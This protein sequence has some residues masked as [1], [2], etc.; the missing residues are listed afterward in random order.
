MVEEDKSKE[1]RF[2]KSEEKKLESKEER[3]ETEEKKP[4]V[5]DAEREEV[6]EKKEVEK[7]EDEQVEAEK[8]VEKKEEKSKGEPEEG[9]EGR[10]EKKRVEEKKEEKKGKKEKKFEHNSRKSLKESIRN[11]YVKKYKTV[12]AM[13]FT[14]FLILFLSIFIFSFQRGYLLNKDISLKGGVVV[15]LPLKNEADFNV[16]IS[17][18]RS[19]FPNKD[20]TVRLLGTTSKSIS[21]ESSD[22]NKTQILSVLSQI[23]DFSDVIKSNNYTFITVG[24][25]LG[26]SFFKQTIKA[27]IW[28][29]IL[30][31]VVV[32]LY[33][34]NF[35]PSL[36]VAWNA[37]ADLAETLA[38]IVMLNMKFSTASIAALLMLIG[39]SVDTNILLTSRVLKAARDKIIPLIFNSMRTGLAMS[40]TTMVTTFFAYLVT[41]SMV[42]RQIMFILTVGMV[43]DTIN[44]WLF[45]A[46]L[47]RWYLE[48]KYSS[49]RK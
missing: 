29:F 47:L 49:R 8:G 36:F 32:L 3:K 38:V 7:K 1:K 26:E 35:T 6:K 10:K 15:T 44:T 18:F 16:V 27:I 9:E 40:L 37:F 48:N 19:A 13:S 33:F 22:L 39:Y 17:K 41:Q 28:S 11:F 24:S 5:K 46:P 14:L 45:N 20:V 23:P 2:E 4:E 30:M 21:I 25:A 34:R 31:S 43:F 12:L 42:I